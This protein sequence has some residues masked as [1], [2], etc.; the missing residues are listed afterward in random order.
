MPDD[1]VQIQAAVSEMQTQITA[2]QAAIEGNSQSGLFKQAPFSG[3]PNEDIA[4]WLAKFD[5]LAGFY[6]WN[7]VKKLNALT[8]NLSGPAL[9]WYQTLPAETAAD[10]SAVTKGLKERFGA[11]NL[12]FIFRQELNARKQGPNEPLSLF[13]EDIIR[14]CQRL[15]LTDKEMMNVFINGL[16][17]D[18]KN[19]VI[20][21]QPKTFAD[22][23]NLAR[24]RDA[25]SSNS[26]GR[27]SLPAAQSVL[28]DQR[29]K[30]LEGQVNLLISLAA[31]KKPLTVSSPPVHAL[32]FEHSGLPVDNA[33]ELHF[34]SKTLPSQFDVDAPTLVTNLKNEIVAA[35]QGGFQNQ[36]SS[37]RWGQPQQQRFQ[38]GARGRNLRTTDGQPICNVCQQVGHVAR[39]CNFRL[40]PQGNPAAQQASF[41]SQPRFR[42]PFPSQN[43]P[44]FYANQS[45]PQFYNQPQYQSSQPQFQYQPRFQVDQNQQHL[46][47]AGSSTWGN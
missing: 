37:F 22:A 29:I 4:E 19:H 34:A 12:E 23:D 45:Q 16:S 36:Q 26:G 44:R 15:S 18:I 47:G 41:R 1:Q 2:F 40:A 13:T 28:Q 20:L 10:I 6:N 8:F 46:N 24:L 30:E 11:T 31:Q 42:M 35:I 25:V 21:N 32:S 33:N 9:A 43:Q 3:M 14:K 17:D 39:Y 27:T 7:D 5:R 38:G